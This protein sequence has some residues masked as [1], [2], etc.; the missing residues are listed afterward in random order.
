M[1]RAFGCLLCLLLLW[2]RPAQAQI[3]VT[4]ALVG[5]QTTI[6]AIQNV[7]TAA[8]MVLS[9]AN[10]VLELTPLDEILIAAEIVE[11]LA[12]IGAIIED[13]QGLMQDVQALQD[14]FNPYDIPRTLPAMRQRITAMDEAIHNARSYALKAQR[15]VTT[16]LSAVRHII[17]LVEGIQA[18]TGNMSS[19]QTLLQVETTIS[20]ILTTLTVQAASHQRTDTLERLRHQVVIEMD[21]EITRQY[22]GVWFSVD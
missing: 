6:S 14:L 7:I 1:R 12:L 5:A 2:S 22:W 16:L 10:Q 17:G 4:D 21:K 9:V 18:L 11:D 19:N 20:K 8:N 3:P 13:A 15:L